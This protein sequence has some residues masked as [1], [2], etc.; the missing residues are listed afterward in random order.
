M[1][2]DLVRLKDVNVLATYRERCEFGVLVESIGGTVRC[3][4]CGSRARIKDRPVVR[5]VD[6]PSN[7]VPF[8]LRWKRHRFVCGNSACDVNS[9]LHDDPR[10]AAKRC[11]LTTRAAKWATKQVGLGR[12]VSEVAKELGCSW[13]VVNDA[14]AIYGSALLEADTKRLNKTDAIGLDET[15]FVKPKKHN[16]R[17][18]CTTVTDSRNR[19]LIDILPTREIQEVAR[20]I[21]EQPAQWKQRVRFGTLDMS[22]AYSAVFCVVLPRAKQIVDPFHAIQLANRA[23]DDIRRR[24]QVE[25]L[26]HRGRKDDPLYRCRRRLLTAEERLSEQTTQRLLSLLELGDP[27]G[28]VS[29]AYRVKERFR[30]F[31]KAPTTQSAALLLDELI[32]HCTRK[33]VSPELQRFGRT[34]KRWS[35]KLLNWHDMRLSNAATESINNLIKRIKR[36]GFGFT[37]F[38]NY[39]IRAL[40]YAGKPNWRILDSIVVT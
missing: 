30:D 1:V 36:I 2:R 21:D 32:A 40:L 22:T 38:R 10:L 5:Y 29:L 11:R 18:Y 13:H 19:Q 35:T 24:V 14:V 16:R 12:T 3:P 9:W 23:L 26:G 8:S 31:Y 6:F 20:W 27:N 39:R 37:N 28:E 7:G 17:Q 33:T 4:G 25:Q 34:L 15:S